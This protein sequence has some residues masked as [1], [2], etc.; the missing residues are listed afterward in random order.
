MNKRNVVVFGAG[1]SGKQ[2]IAVLKH[3]S[4]YK[5]VGVIDDSVDLNNKTLLE[6]PIFSR[7][8]LQKLISQKSVSLIFFA[9]ANIQ[10]T[11]RKE[12]LDWLSHFRVEV[13]TLPSISEF[14]ECKVNFS[15]LRDISIEDVLG[16]DEV[17]ITQNFSK[18]CLFNKT[19]LVT[20][21]GGSI[22]S[23]LSKQIIKEKPNQLVLFEQSEFALYKIHKYL[24]PIAESLNIKI[25]PILGSVLNKNRL[26]E[27]FKKFKPNTIYHAAAYKHVPLVEHN[28]KEG[29][30]TNTFGTLVLAKLAIEFQVTNFLLISTDKAVR[31]SNFMGASKRLAEMVIQALQEKSSHTT[32]TVVR[33]GNVLDSSGSVIPLFKEQI[34]SGGPVTVTHPE[35]TRYFMTI[36]EAVSLVLQASGMSNGGEVFVLEMGTPI[37]IL[38]LA[39]KMIEL[40]KNDNIEVKFTGLRAGEKLYEEL[41]IGNKSEKTD[42]PRI[43]KVYEDFIELEKLKKTLKKINSLLEQNDFSMLNSELDQIIEGYIHNKNIVDAL[44]N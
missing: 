11:K 26:K 2:L 39:K 32:F 38:E 13:R 16:R 6:V 14:L 15:S 3:H 44:N 30:Q 12:I 37:K 9:I 25:Y 43:I 28:I 29:I 35:I 20:G 22:G 8:Q 41:L 21:A 4:L 23:E 31:P 1:E 19:V 36:A 34:E 33:F 17:R 5:V 18:K 42:H 40:S 27:V 7:N 10:F 24:E